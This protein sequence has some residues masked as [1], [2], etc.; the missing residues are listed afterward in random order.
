L[1]RIEDR[2]L[3]ELYEWISIEDALRSILRFELIETSPASPPGDDIRINAIFPRGALSR[4]RIFQ[5]I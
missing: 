5:I 4:M 1:Y 3:Y 2:F